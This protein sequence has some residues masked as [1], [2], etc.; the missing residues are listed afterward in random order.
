MVQAQRLRMR[1]SLTLGLLLG[2]SVGAAFTQT[3]T[4]QGRVTDAQTGA[5]LPQANVVVTATGISTGAATGSSGA[6]EVKDL[7]A[8]TYTVTVSYVGYEKMVIAGVEVKAGETR[9][10]NIALTPTAIM[11]NPIVVSA[12]R[13]QEKALEAPAAI[14]VLEAAQIHRRPALTATD[15]LR[16]VPAVDITT[17]GIAQSTVAVRGFSGT[18]SSALHSLTDNR[19]ANLPSLRFNLYSL[20]PL[21][22]EDISR[23]EVVSGPGSALYGPNSANGIM[24]IITRSPFDS[25]GT[26]LSL[27]GGGRDFLN[28]STRA[29]SGG[30]NIYTASLRHAGQIT[31]KIGYKI[32]AR[33]FQGRDWETYLPL[34]VAPRQITFGRQTSAGRVAE[35]SAVTSQGDFEV[36]HIAAETRWDFRLNDYTTLI[37]NGGFNQMDQI[38]LTAVGAAQ[39]K[40]WRYTYAQA[41]F[42][43]K[44]LFVQGFI[45]AS[46]AGDTYFLR[47]G[48]RIIDNSKLFV[49]Q[50]QHGYSFG[51]RQR[52]TYGVD[53]LFTRPDTKNTITGRN[54]NKDNIDEL[55]VYVQ[56]ETKVFSKVDLVAA[57]RVDDHNHI[58]DPVFSPRAAVVFK[59]TASHN[60]RLTY[61]RA[62][63]TPSTNNLFLDILSANIPNPLNPARPLLSVRARGVPS[64]TGFTFRR[65]SDGRPLMMTQLLPAGTGYVPATVNSVWPALRQ[66]LI[67]QSPANLRALLN[68]TL[69]QQF[70]GTVLGD[71]QSLNTSTGKFVPVPDAIDLAP[72]KPSINNTFELGYK[73]VIGKKLFVAIDVYHSR[74]KDRIALGTIVETPNVFANPQQ[75][76]TALQPTVEAIT[77]AL[78][79]QG[80]PAPQAQAQAAAIISGL[81]TSAARLPLG[82]V[83]PEQ[84][85]NDTDVLL[86]YRNYG[87]LSVNGLDLALTYQANPN[88]VFSGNY[89]FVTKQGFNLFKRANRVFFADVGGVED[90]AF[91]APGHKAGL[92]IQ[93]RNP[94]KGFDAEL[95]GRY[96]EGFPMETGVYSGEIQTYTV[97]DANLAYDLPFS[98]NTRV[99]LSALNLLDKKHRE[100]VGAPILGRLVLA[101]ITQSL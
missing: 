44:D 57:A 81:V 41:R 76:S 11:F 59:P 91:N 93:Y 55:G 89:S 23:I 37:F 64:A 51:E 15:Y 24:H 9:L 97:F 3:A 16:G 83:S 26:S 48:D 87:D 66:V 75:L 78:I 46:D 92:S 12:S 70:S 60:L 47:N 99:A 61:N 74:F 65:G 52:F 85:A 101:R 25:K 40:D 68:A 31:E 14:S 49:G 67:A 2:L 27:G 29:P 20:I 35:G 62:F 6:F 18:L 88:W 21:T 73:G 54:E 13:H 45:N 22:N 32:S 71:L 80:V 95:R 50:A 38:E 1:T 42:N 53:A 34:D 90:V 17:N 56:S 33:Y 10:L 84:I 100:F 28:L 19:Y 63:T 36:E 58:K 7:A 79:A 96:V 72:L 77:N 43:Y 5:P 98:K 82:V 8:G 30:R 94:Q 39:G 4:L 86:S 69:P